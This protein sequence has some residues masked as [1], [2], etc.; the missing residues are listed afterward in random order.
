[1]SKNGYLHAVLFCLLLTGCGGRL[2]NVASLPSAPAPEITTGEAAGLNVGAAA[3]AGDEALER[4]SANLPLAGVIAVDVKLINRT[5]GL[6]EVDRLRFEL[7]DRSGRGLKPLAPRAALKAVMKYYGNSFYAI[8]ARQRTRE[9]YD[10]VS[11]DKL[12]AL[13]AQEER[14]GILFYQAP[15]GTTDVGGMALTITGGA[16]PMSVSVGV[17]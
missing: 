6:V 12:V 4:F 1:M 17:R 10:A 15:R 3:L 16:A 13:A 5:S 9:D 11:L 2:Y 7:K 14:R 8:A